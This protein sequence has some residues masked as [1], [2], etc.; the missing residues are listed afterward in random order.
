MKI[1]GPYRRLVTGIALCVALAWVSLVSVSAATTRSA[2]RPAA[3]DFELGDSQGLPVE[4]SSYRGKVVMVDFWAT[5]CT[6]CKVEIPWFMEF[7]RKYKNAGLETIGA[8]MDAEGWDKVR[9]YLERHP[10]NYR[11]VVGNDR[12]AKLFSITSLP[13][14]LLIDRDGRIADQHVGMVDKDVWERE[15]LTLLQ[16]KPK[17]PTTPRD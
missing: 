3:P 8:A 2:L 1:S 12:V 15:I 6:G 10:F 5:W 13:M 16:E 14:T 11:I 17:S 7:E 9:P 4:L